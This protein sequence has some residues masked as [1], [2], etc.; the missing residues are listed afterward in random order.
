M[1]S[2]VLFLK[3]F[4]VACDVIVVLDTVL[5]VSSSNPLY[6]LS[7]WYDYDFSCLLDLPHGMLIIQNHHFLLNIRI[8]FLQK[9]FQCDIL[10]LFNGL[11]WAVFFKPKWPIL[12]GLNQC[13]QELGHCNHKSLHLNHPVDWKRD[14]VVATYA[15]YSTRYSKYFSH[16]NHMNS[17]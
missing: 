12:N 8:T 17:K 15:L 16:E 10:R 14:K 2:I 4:A 1:Q 5:V 7:L 11:G 9:C 6:R 13:K 3:R